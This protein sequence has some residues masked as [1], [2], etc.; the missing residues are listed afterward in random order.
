M[1]IY[2]YWYKSFCFIS[3]FFMMYLHMYT[4]L[5]K[6]Y[7]YKAQYFYKDKNTD[8]DLRLVTAHIYKTTPFLPFLTP[9]NNLKL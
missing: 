1:F 5:I 3:V 9:L 8:V 2:F 6:K 7:T 4:K